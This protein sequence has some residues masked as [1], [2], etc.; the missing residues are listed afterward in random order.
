[1]ARYDSGV[2][3]N[4]GIR[5]SSA[6]SPQ[7]QPRRTMAKP[8]L[9]LQNKTDAQIIDF[10]ATHKAAMAGNANFPTPLPTPAEFD[11]ALTAASD[12]LAEVDA[13]FN[14]CAWRCR[15]R[16]ISSPRSRRY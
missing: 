3:Y 16:M 2:T 1:M 14:A 12:K 13:K 5:Y 6:P 11:A 4:S 10:A 8:K 9:E 15:R 7:S